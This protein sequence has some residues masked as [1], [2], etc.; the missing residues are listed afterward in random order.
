MN[1][2]EWLVEYD[3]AYDTKYGAEA[4]MISIFKTEDEAN[5]FAKKH[6][7]SKV[8]KVEYI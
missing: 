8:V 5:E 1:K 7:D 6:A 4:M 2:T 3:F